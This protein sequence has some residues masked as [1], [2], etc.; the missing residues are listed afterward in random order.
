MTPVGL[1]EISEEQFLPGQG[2]RSQLVVNP[3][4][5]TGQ[6]DQGAP[7]VARVAGAR[8]ESPLFQPADGAAGA[9]A[10]HGDPVGHVID[11]GAPL[12]AQDQDHSQL[13]QIQVMRTGAFAE[14][15]ER[16]LVPQ[17]LNQR[18]EVVVELQGM[19]WFGHAGHIHPGQRND[20]NIISM[21]SQYLTYHIIIG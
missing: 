19:F 9:A 21:I 12:G 16:N 18:G 3:D 5:L 10:I 15:M 13:P 11:R 20:K 4:P 17:G 7:P 1:G 8:N 2:E 14:R 6:I